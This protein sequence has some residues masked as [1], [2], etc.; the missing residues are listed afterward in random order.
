MS[1]PSE[2]TPAERM[3]LTCTDLFACVMGANC[4]H[5]AKTTICMPVIAFWRG[6]TDTVSD[7]VSISRFTGVGLRA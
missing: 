7:A 1:W 2:V 5:A 6:Q 4:K 3:C